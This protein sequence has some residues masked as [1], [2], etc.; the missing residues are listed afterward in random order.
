[1][2]EILC[3]GSENYEGDEMAH[4]LARKIKNYKDFEFVVAESPQKV[5]EFEG[6]DGKKLIIMD[7]VQNLQEVKILSVNDLVRGNS[8][9]AHDADLGFYLQLLYITGKVAEPIIIG[10][11]LGESD[12]E[13]LAK[14]I[15]EILSII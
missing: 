15:L 3:F 4:I 7:V 9:T 2:R 8:V 10:L 5:L 1:M 14:N 13:K 11:P 12:L 6:S